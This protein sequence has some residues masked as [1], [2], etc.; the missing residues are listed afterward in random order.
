MPVGE[1]KFMAEIGLRDKI[2][3]LFLA[4]EGGALSGEDLS[5]QLG[6]SR[7]AIW[8][9]ISHLRTAG[10]TIDALP[11][12]GYHLVGQPDLLLAAAVKS[13]LAT[14]VIGCEV[15]HHHSI[16]STNQRAQELAE[17]GAKS[18]TVVI[19]EEQTAGRGRLGRCWSSPVGVNLYAS[20]L[21]R[22]QL[23]PMQ[24][25]Q[26]TFLSAVAVARAVEAVAGIKVNVKWPNDILL[27]GKK[28][29]GLLNEI[30]TDMDGIHYA[31][32]GIGVN[33]NMSADQFPAD[34]RYPA[35]SV[36]L[37]TGVPVNRLSF[38]QELC[39][40]L[41]S[42][43]AL[44]C[45]QG[46]VPIRLAWESLFNMLGSRVSVDYGQEKLCGC[47]AGIAQDGALLLRLDNGEQQEI[48]AGDVDPIGA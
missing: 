20:V 2:L 10:Y 19:A 33:L 14:E 45:T 12:R 9:H 13:G 4:A 27:G 29:A 25:A 42:L 36:L 47:V 32:L 6:V 23:L 35:T 17:Q 15:E 48:Y 26:L 28:I 34:L 16:D 24:A 31:I 18:G 37:A 7:A 21:L 39:R 3:S 11:S 8:K 44:L 46:F 1:G 30:S 43:Y 22:P 40:Q 5:R 41:D 38:T